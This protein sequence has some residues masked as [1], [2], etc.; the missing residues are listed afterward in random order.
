MDEFL[1]K[2]VI[3]P[4][5]PTGRKNAAI[6]ATKIIF[7]KFDEQ[8]SGGQKNSRYVKAFT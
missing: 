4:I 3:S 1:L 7:V 2:N 6:A 5:A 8:A